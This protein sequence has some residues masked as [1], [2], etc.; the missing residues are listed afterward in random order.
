MSLISWRT[1]GTHHPTDDNGSKRVGATTFCTARTRLRH[2]IAGP[3][4][5]YRAKGASWLRAKMQSE[6]GSTTR[7]MASAE[8]RGTVRARGVGYVRALSRADAAGRGG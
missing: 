3:Q 2:A 1:S 4:P 6:T 8:R 5:G 7:P